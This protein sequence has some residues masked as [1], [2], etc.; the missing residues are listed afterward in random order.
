MFPVFDVVHNLLLES[1]FNQA[2][3]CLGF[4]VL[5]RWLYFTLPPLWMTQTFL[6]EQL[7]KDELCTVKDT[8]VNLKTL[9]CWILKCKRNVGQVRPISLAL[10]YFQIFYTNFTLPLWS[11]NYYYPHFTDKK[12]A[13]LWLTQGRMACYV[14]DLGPKAQVCPY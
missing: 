2:R 12:S 9:I 5:Q 4:G 8:K 14:G 1:W 6:L 7:V 3:P 13:K 10:F 11:K